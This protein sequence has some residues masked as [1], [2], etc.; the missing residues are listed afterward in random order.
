M[1]CCKSQ[2][3]KHNKHKVVQWIKQFYSITGLIVWTCLL[4]YCSYSGDTCDPN[5]THLLLKLLIL[6]CSFEAEK[7][8]FVD[9][10]SF[11]FPLK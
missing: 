4:L 3:L 9:E 7:I 2:P 6:N 1:L 11:V 5:G 10:M 8:G